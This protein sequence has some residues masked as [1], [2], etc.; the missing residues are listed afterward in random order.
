MRS[1]VF[2]W[3]C[4]SRVELDS[5][6]FMETIQKAVEAGELKRSAKFEK[7]AK[8]VARRPVPR[9]VLG[10]PGGAAD[11]A[12]LALVA[13]IRGRAQKSSSKFL[14]E[15]ERKYAGSEDKGKKEKKQRR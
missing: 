3:L 14:E 1:S 2:C 5:H 10:A 9:D 7:W 6:R 12:G 11:D 8:A 13:A 4:C 15:L